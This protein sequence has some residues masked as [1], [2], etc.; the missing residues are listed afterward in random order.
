MKKYTVFRGPYVLIEDIRKRYKPFFKEYSD[1]QPRLSLDSPPMGCPFIGNKRIRFV[2]KDN[3]LRPGVCEICYKN[4]DNYGKHVNLSEHRE[5]AVNDRNYEE[6]DAMM[7]LI[8][9]EHFKNSLHCGDTSK[10]LNVDEF[11]GVIPDLDKFIGD[12]LDEE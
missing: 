2:K 7:L 10:I 4:Y 6:L 5:F 11:E 12:Y 3:D 1:K 8:N 9:E